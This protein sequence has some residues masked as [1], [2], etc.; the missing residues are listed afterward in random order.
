MAILGPVFA[1]VAL[2]TFVVFRLGYI[3][4]RAIKRREVDFRFFEVY[5][6]YE[7]P[8]ELAAGSRHLVN[9]FE[10]PVL[11]YLV[12]VLI[13]VTGQTTPLLVGLAWAYAALRYVHSYIHLGPNVVIWRFRVFVLSWLVLITIWTAYGV[14]LVRANT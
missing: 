4:F 1:L 11:F 2:T 3:R 10:A 9:L 13:L 12:C 8:K 6:G 5:R 7:E 14:Q